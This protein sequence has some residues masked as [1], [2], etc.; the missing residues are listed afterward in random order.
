MDPQALATAKSQ[1]EH[2]KLMDKVELF[3]DPYEA[4]KGA[5]ALVVATEWSEFRS[6]DAVRLKLVM[7]G[8]HVFDGRNT[9]VAEE[10]VEAGLV[11]RG[12]GRPVLGD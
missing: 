7:R 9:L 5:D 8:R 10:I 6:P 12:V 3:T 11:Y 4:C 2:S 1:L